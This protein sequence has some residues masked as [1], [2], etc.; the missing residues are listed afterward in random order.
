MDALFSEGNERK[1]E[2]E[3]K[4]VT[5]KNDNKIRWWVRKSFPFHFMFV[6]ILGVLVLAHD[7]CYF[8]ENLINCCCGEIKD[9]ESKVPFISLCVRV[10]NS[11][12]VCKKVS[13]VGNFQMVKCFMYV[14]RIIW[15]RKIRFLLVANY[16]FFCSFVFLS[17]LIVCIFPF[18]S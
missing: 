9:S 2:T 12:G 11:Y 4:S 14:N 13:I 7:G 1:K 8:V 6:V 3:K 16:F 5:E 17:Y 10:C 15:R 18:G